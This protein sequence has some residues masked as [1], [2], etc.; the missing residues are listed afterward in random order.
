M[1]L[2]IFIGIVGISCWWLALSSSNRAEEPFS[3]AAVF[4]RLLLTI[5]SEVM[6]GMGVHLADIPPNILTKQL[7]VS[8]ILRY[9]NAT[10]PYWFAVVLCFYSPIPDLSLQ[11]KGFGFVSIPEGIPNNS[12]PHPLLYYNRGTRGF[13]LGGYY[14]LHSDLHAGVK[15]LESRTTRL[16]LEQRS[17]VVFPFCV[18]YIDWCCSAYFTNAC[19]QLSTAA[20]ETKVRPHVN[21]RSWKFVSSS[22]PETRQGAKVLTSLH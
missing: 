8:V 12:Y 3:T 11:R 14:H 6:N 15:I 10:F 21:F 22:V 19:H 4:L 18:P 7:I 9:W 1:R 16:L 20:K 5:L 2:G 13:C 17:H